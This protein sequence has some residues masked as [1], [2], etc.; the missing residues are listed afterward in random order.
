[1]LRQLTEAAREGGW[2]YHHVQRSDYGRQIGLRGFPDLILIRGR[3]L[4]AVEVKAKGGVATP[5]QHQWLHA[6]FLAGAKG[7]IVCWPEDLGPWLR[8]LRRAAQ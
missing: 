3:E 1:M 8:R 7:A 5:E 4:F 6:F 2:I